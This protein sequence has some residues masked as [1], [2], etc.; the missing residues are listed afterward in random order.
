MVGRRD[1]L[2]APLDLS[3]PRF[4][5]ALIEEAAD[6][7]WDQRLT[8]F[9]DA[10][11]WAA[12]GS[13]IR[14]R[15]HI[16]VNLL[17]QQL[18]AAEEDIRRHVEGL[19]TE[20]AW[21]HAVAPDRMTGEARA[22]LEQY[23]Y[24]V[25]RLGKGTGRYAGQRRLEIREAM[26]RCRPSVP[27]WIMPIYRIAEQLRVTPNM[28]DV[29]VVDEASQAGLEATFLQYLAPK[30]V[31]I[32]DDK[33]VSPAAV[34]TDQQVLRDLAAQYLYDDKYKASWQDPQRSLFDEA[35]MRYGGL[36]TLVEHRRCVPEIIGF[37]NRVALPAGRHSPN[38]GPP[39]WS[40]ST[41][42]H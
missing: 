1:E 2:G 18:D 23:A 36:I 17:Q 9:E 39:V 22:N 3:A 42:A 4:C 40:G 29:V 6:T 41:R 11:N 12:T 26:D 20:R 27:V 30:I 16:D 31:V 28:F 7:A 38:T 15:E 33:Q 35:K 21:M 25:R 24:L 37:S 14:D 34:G 32:G 13:W 5:A 8:R 19:A 10:W